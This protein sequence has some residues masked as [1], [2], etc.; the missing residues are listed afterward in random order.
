[1]D[2]YP[3][4]MRWCHAVAQVRQGSGEAGL[5]ELEEVEHRYRAPWYVRRDIAEAYE[6]PQRD[7]EAW[8]WYCA[9]AS[10]PGELW[11][12]V[13][14]LQQMGQLL[15]RQGRWQA[16]LDHLLLA[17][18]LAAR[19][20][21]WGKVAEKC[22]EQL[23]E[24]IQRSG[25]QLDPPATLPDAPPEPEPLLAACRQAWADGRR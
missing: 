14:M 16:A 1:M 3:F 2:R 4:V 12:R 20:E 24:I 11:N 13:A 22:R 8:R 21:G 7:E 9:A 25:D 10:A 17:W 19:H 23:A 15:E 18:T 5:R 6:K